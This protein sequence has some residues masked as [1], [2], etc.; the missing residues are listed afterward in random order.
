MRLRACAPARVMPQLD[1][2]CL[3]PELTLYT[4][5]RWQKRSA[6]RRL[7]QALGGRLLGD[8]RRAV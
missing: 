1:H 3:R 5:G 7:S 2:F 6:L 4:R 8:R